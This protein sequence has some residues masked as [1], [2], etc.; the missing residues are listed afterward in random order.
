MRARVPRA[1]KSHAVAQTA[2]RG[3]ERPC[4]GHHVA[5]VQPVCQGLQGGVG[6]IP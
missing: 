3:G 4:L 5:K 1:R 2:G 6:V